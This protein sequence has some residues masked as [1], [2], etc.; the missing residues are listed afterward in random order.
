MHIVITVNELLIVHSIIKRIGASNINSLIKFWHTSDKTA[1]GKFIG[2]AGIFHIVH[3]NLQPEIEIGYRF[4]V[5]CWGQG[6]RG[7]S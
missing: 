5:K 7:T 3:Y 2:Q 1:T 6:L 4:R